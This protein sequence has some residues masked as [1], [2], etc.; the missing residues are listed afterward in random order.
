MADRGRPIP[1]ATVRTLRRLRAA[2]GV[3][4]AARQTG[5]SPVTVIKYTKGDENKQGS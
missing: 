4:A 2:V 5:V 1:A 3:R